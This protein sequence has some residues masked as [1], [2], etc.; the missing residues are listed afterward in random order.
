MKSLFRYE[1]GSGKSSCVRR[2]IVCGHSWRVVPFLVFDCPG[3]L[4]A[5]VKV[6]KTYQIK[7]LTC[8]CLN[9]LHKVCFQSNFQS[10]RRDLNQK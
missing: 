4:R 8:R 7:V 9:Q 5:V 6:R 2:E 1:A 3:F 10:E